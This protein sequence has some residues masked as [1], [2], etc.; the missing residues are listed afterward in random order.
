MFDS[1]MN[2]F[3]KPIKTTIM[4]IGT[5]E[6]QCENWNFYLLCSESHRCFGDSVEATDACSGKLQRG[7]KALELFWLANHTQ[8]PTK[9]LQKKYVYNIWCKNYQFYMN[10]W[11]TVLFGV[12]AWWK[13]SVNM[14]GFFPLY[15]VLKLCC[16]VR[17]LG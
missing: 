8:K 6:Y 4:A 10:N 11:T 14:N 3:L 2:L 9:K 13:Q 12:P 1:S 15:P 7:L 16:S 17:P 5:R